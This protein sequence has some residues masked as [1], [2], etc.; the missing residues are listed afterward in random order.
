M[1]LIDKIPASLDAKRANGRI[2]K[3]PCEARS[4]GYQP[5]CASSLSCGGPR[6]RSAPLSAAGRGVL[7]KR[8]KRRLLPALGIFSRG[9]LA[10]GSERCIWI[11]WIGSISPPRLS[12]SSHLPLCCNLQPPLVEALKVECRP[13]ALIPLPFPDNWS[14]RL[15]PSTVV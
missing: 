13:P 3:A 6:T 7:P 1:W 12:H 15:Q 5:C 2:G 11:H 9:S 8:A 4:Y 14:P 10:S